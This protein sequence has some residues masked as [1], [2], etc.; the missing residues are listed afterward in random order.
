MR[1]ALAARL[2]DNAA[3]IPG[4]LYAA[5]PVWM[6]EQ[7]E[8]ASALVY[9]P[10]RFDAEHNGQPLQG[11]YDIT[12]TED[13]RVLP[14]EKKEPVTAGYRSLGRNLRPTD[15]LD[16][17]R[18]RSNDRIAARKLDPLDYQGLQGWTPQQYCV[19]NMA[20][21]DR[22]G[23][24]LDQD[25]ELYRVSY[26]PG[27]YFPTSRGVPDGSWDPRGRRADLLRSGPGDRDPECGARVAVRVA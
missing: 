19:A 9:H 25:G 23:L 27:A 10:E 6:W 17:L 21:L 2:R 14:E 22:S 11:G 16:L 18:G 15:Y 7:Y 5:E 8:N 1:D 3:R 26:L 13:I 24:P 20:S 4:G 12:L